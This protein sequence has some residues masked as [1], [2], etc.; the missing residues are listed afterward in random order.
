M[1]WGGAGSETIQSLASYLM[2]PS[3]P[4]AT[5]A[6]VAVA[7][8]VSRTTVSNAYNRPDQ[9]S[10]ALRERILTTAAEKSPLRSARVGTVA[11]WLLAFRFWGIAQ[12]VIFY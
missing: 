7:V 2:D 4:R 11:T 12:R 3:R 1:R 6:A 8:G 9:L 10:V 5:L